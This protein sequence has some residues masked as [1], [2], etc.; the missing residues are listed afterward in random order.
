MSEELNNNQDQHQDMHEEHNFDGITELNN[1]AP[2]WIVI[3]FLV[4]IGF[5]G[6]YAIRY[7]GHPNNEM[8][9]K[10]EYERKVAAFEAKKK[11][12]QMAAQGGKELNIEEMIA[13][14]AKQFTE[15]GCIA[16]HGTNGEGNNIGPNLTDNYWLNGCSEEDVIAIIA[17]GKPE[18]GMTPYKAMMSE[19]QIKNVSLYILE[20]L[21]GSN[22]ENGKE[23]QGDECKTES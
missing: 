14:G 21:V 4:T 18:K 8:D 12:M 1:R 11:E 7:F 5:S 17:N 15:K 6:I 9:Q 13:D 23:A 10:S 19:A 2:A 3:I 22:P 16:C 20:E